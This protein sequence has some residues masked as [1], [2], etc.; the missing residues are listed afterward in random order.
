MVLTSSALL[1]GSSVLIA[2]DAAP[3][4]PDQPG[5]HPA[6]Q[7]AR[8]AQDII[9]GYIDAT[10]GRAAWAALTSIR[11]MGHIVLAGMPIEGRFVVY[12]T[13]D[14]YRLG[15]DM[16]QVSETADVVA[17]R[18]VTVRKGDTAWRSMNGGPATALSAIEQADLMRKKAFNPLLNA[19]ERYASMIVAGT[20]LI[21]GAP[22]FRLALDPVDQAAPMEHRW[23]DVAT[24]LQTKFAQ[25]P[26]GGGLTAEVFLSDYRQ[27]GRVK[28][29]HRMV[30]SSVGAS[31]ERTF[32]AMQTNVTIDDCLFERPPAS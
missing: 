28:L 32:D 1:A 10:G 3:T 16:F 8:T 29:H 15:V 18:Q 5:T 21:D 31:M 20:E 22:C 26:R 7:P 14:A 13:V 19:A 24:G 27:V 2:Q 4:P 6:P 12:Q 25:T 17:T 30:V 9:D 11:G 23:F